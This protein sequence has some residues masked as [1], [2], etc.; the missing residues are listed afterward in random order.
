MTAADENRQRSAPELAFRALQGSRDH[1]RD[2]RRGIRAGLAPDPI[3]GS[4]AAVG[5]AGSRLE[6]QSWYRGRRDRFRPCTFPTIT[7][8]PERRSDRS[9]S[10]AQR[11]RLWRRGGLALPPTP[12]PAFV[13]T[14]VQRSGPAGSRCPYI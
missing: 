8:R 2:A 13:S 14:R 12:G 9:V 1:A 11:A 7:Y 5:T 10:D 4:R 6:R 3:T